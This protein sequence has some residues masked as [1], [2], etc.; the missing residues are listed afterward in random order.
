MA[1]GL[2]EIHFEEHVV[3]YLTRIIEP[4]FFEYRERKP[5]DYDKDLCM[6]PQDT[7]SF[8]GNT[9]P[10]KVENLNRQY[11]EN[12][13]KKVIENIS[14]EVNKRKTLDVMREGVKDR[15]QHLDLVYFKPNHN[16][17]PEHDEAYRKNI[18]SVIRQLKYSKK[19]NNSI[20]IVLS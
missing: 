8:L 2:K 7:I 6:I 4:D 18:F 1:E 16:R 11:G 10:K 14:S 3:K 20:D 13:Y 9:Q 12:T 19:N 5:E 15:G 17:T